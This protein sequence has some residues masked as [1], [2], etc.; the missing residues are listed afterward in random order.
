VSGPAASIVVATRDRPR[1]LA[2]CLASLGR[3]SLAAFEVVVVDDGSADPQAVA[4]AVARVPGARLLQGGGRGPAAARNAG[5]RSARAPTICF[6]D[7]DCEPAPDWAERLAARIAA[8]AAAAAGRTA[9]AVPSNVAAA[10]SQA[11]TNHLT[12]A[13]VEPASGRLGF[14]PSCNLAC[15]TEVALAVPFD[16]RY[17]LAAGEDRAWCAR[18][19][20]RGHALV[21]E[22]DALVLHRQDLTPVS[23]WRQQL[24][25]GRG[26]LRFWGEGGGP[27]E[28]GFYLALLLRG[29]AHGPR[30]GALVCLGQAAIAAG[31][32]R[33]ALSRRSREAPAPRR[34]P[35]PGAGRGG[36]AGSPG[37]G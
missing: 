25:Y 15:R 20:E 13:S 9:N 12:E 22:P 11:L 5:A 28:P 27:A 36:S 17:R 14:A 32:A 1:S 31:M 8:G 3:Q 4:A 7:D 6:T 18:L 2:R 33:E 16:E 24:R 19:A 34:T 29:F 10:A 30:T 37:A 23:F 21:F 35:S 26:A